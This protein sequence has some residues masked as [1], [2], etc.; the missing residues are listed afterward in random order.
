MELRSDNMEVQ[1][2]RVTTS[3]QAELVAGLAKTIWYDHYSPII[4]REQVEYMLGKYQTSKAIL[5]QTE[6]EGNYYFLIH[7]EFV[8]VGYIGIVEKHNELFLSKLYILNTERG[9]GIGH[10]AIDFLVTRC[11]E[12]GAPYI[13]LTVNKQNS[14]SIGAYEKLGF[15]IYGEVE[16]DIGAGYVMDDFLMRLRVNPR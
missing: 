13:T 14:D 9:K 10:F 7:H 4:G 16:S 15:E 6:L 11:R 3:S 2:K 5:A 8:P 12:L 1:I